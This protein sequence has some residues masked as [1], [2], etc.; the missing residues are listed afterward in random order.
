MRAKPGRFT[1]QNASFLLAGIW[2]VFL[3]YP[4]SRIAWLDAPL[5]IKVLGWTLIAVFAI[6]YVSGLRVLG[7]FVPLGKRPAR[8]A[9]FAVLL[10]LACALIPFLGYGT[11]SMTPYLV[12]YAA[13]GLWRPWRWV[14]GVSIIAV[15]ATVAAIQPDSAEILL[16]NVLLFVVGMVMVQLIERSEEA[17]E[18]ERANLVIAERDKMARDVHD[19]IG[20]SLTVVNLKAQLAQ[21]LVDTDPAQAKTELA[22]IQAIV[23]EALGGVR[24]TV[25]QARSTTIADELVTAGDALASGGVGVEVIGDPASINGTIGLV[26]GWVVREA[27]TNVLRHAHA[28][29]CRFTFTPTS[30]AVEDDGDGTSGREGNGIRGMR[31]RIAAAGGA[32]SVGASELGGTKVEVT[33]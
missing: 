6:I 17:E 24:R 23:S 3:F 33:W 14:V 19:L 5:P 8:I 18:L 12:A 26:G 4:I 20:H 30:M 21:R 22:E 31:E 10:V 27:T 13:Y 1:W 32:L 9:R 29:Q 7:S 25:T 16:I 11:V 2:L 28:S 15:A